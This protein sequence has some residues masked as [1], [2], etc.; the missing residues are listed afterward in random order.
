MTTRNFHEN[1][2]L[3]ANLKYCSLALSIRENINQNYNDI[4]LHIMRKTY[5]KKLIN[6]KCCQGGEETETLTH[7]YIKCHLIQPICEMIQ[8]FLKK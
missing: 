3:I 7:C 1:N 6:S 5:V 8:R 2:I 4:S